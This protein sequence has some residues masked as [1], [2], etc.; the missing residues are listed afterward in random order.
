MKKITVFLLFPFKYI[1]SA[2]AIF[3]NCPLPFAHCLWYIA[4]Y[5]LPIATFLTSCNSNP[6]VKPRGYFNIDLPAQK[7]YTI[8]NR[9]G[10]PYSFEYP[11]YG[12]IVQDSTFFDDKPQNPY[13]IN[14]DFPQYDAKIYLSYLSINEKVV[15]REKTKGGYKDSVGVNTLNKLVNDAFALTNKHSIKA[16]AI[17]EIAVHPSAGVNGFIFEVGGN[18]ASLK[19]FFLTDSSKHFVRGALYFNATPNE[20]SVKPVSQYLFQDMKQLVSSLRWKK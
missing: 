14:I 19:Q 5:L 6:T 20:D 2:K 1:P 13:W 15:F 7:E 17:D 11:V 8:F 12:N 16:N 10:F 18:A 3:T 4:I 9:P